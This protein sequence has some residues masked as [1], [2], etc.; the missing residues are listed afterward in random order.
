M[1]MN[2]AE[3][4]A[5][6]RSAR[7]RGVVAG[8]QDAPFFH[9]LWTD[10]LVMG[11]VGYPQGLPISLA[12]VRDLLA[13]RQDDLLQ[14][15]LLVLRGLGTQ[16]IGECKLGRPDETGLSETD[17]KLLP[18]YWGRGFGTEIKRALL[19]YLFTQT[20]CQVVQATPNVDNSASIRMQEAVGGVR[21]GERTYEPG[22]DAPVG[23]QA[24][25]CYVYHVTRAAWLARQVAG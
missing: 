15:R 18:H 4:T 3:R 6:W 11:N 14:A 10:P 12:E 13:T 5:V 20:D 23:A 16:G 7:L 19:D 21:V 8:P 9:R 1:T 17:V 2:A 22:P 24:V 25:H